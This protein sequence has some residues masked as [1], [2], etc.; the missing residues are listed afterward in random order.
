[1][2]FFDDFEEQLDDET[3][4]VRRV[5]RLERLEAWRQL[6][7]CVRPSTPVRKASALNDSKNKP[8]PPLGKKQQERMR[9]AVLIL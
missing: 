8:R 4:A 9:R 5:L 1:V 2:D 6:D 7:L 3:A